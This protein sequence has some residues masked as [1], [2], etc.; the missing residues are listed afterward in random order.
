MQQAL[1]KQKSWTELT[2]RRGKSPVA[3]K[4]SAA[5]IVGYHPKM[6]SGARTQAGDVRTDSSDCVPSLSL[7][8]GGRAVAGRQAILEIDGRGGSTWIE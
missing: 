4:A 5:T 2:L 3:A 7:H 8:R 6:I 1:R